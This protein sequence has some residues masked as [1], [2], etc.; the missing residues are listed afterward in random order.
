MKEFTISMFDSRE[1]LL[2]AKAKYLEYILDKH[3]EIFR[4]IERNPSCHPE[5]IRYEILKLL[6]ELED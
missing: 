2:E 4:W 3:I 5:N 1:E 6:K